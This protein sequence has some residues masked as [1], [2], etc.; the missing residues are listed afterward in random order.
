MPALCI[1]AALRGLMRAKR[2]R[3]ENNLPRVKEIMME[4]TRRANSIGN[5]TISQVKEAM[6]LTL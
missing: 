1:G 6:G 3:Y 4:G 5:E 2:M